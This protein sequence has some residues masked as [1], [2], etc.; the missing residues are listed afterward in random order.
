M[1]GA[2]QG[3]AQ[4]NA[5]NSSGVIVGED[6]IDPDLLSVGNGFI[7]QNGQATELN[8]LIAPTPNV[9]LAGASGINDVGDIVGIADVTGPDGTQSSVGYELVPITTP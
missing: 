4:A 2:G 8:T 9:R 1:V 7:Y 5:I 6:G 3:A